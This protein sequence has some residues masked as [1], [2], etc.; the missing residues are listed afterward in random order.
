M[1][2]YRKKLVEVEAVLWDKATVAKTP[3]TDYP[4]WLLK[5]LVAPEGTEGSLWH[6]HEG[7]IIGTLEGPHHV[8][9]GNYIIQGVAGEIFSCDPDIFHRTYEKVI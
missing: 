9:L 4:N 2:T 6:S 5:A 3:W 8:S 7:W 1:A